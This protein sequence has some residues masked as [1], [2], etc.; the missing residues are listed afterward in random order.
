MA[1]RTRIPATGEPPDD[2]L[3]RIEAFRGDDLDWRG[4]RT[5]SLVYDAGPDHQ[6]LLKRAHAAYFSENGLNP[7]AFPGLKRLETEIVQ[8]TAGLLNGPPS[9]VGTMTSGGTESLLLAVKTARDRARWR[10]RRP[11]IVLPRTAH[12]AFDKAGEWFGVELRHAPVDAQ[13]RA[14]VGAMRR[15]VDRRTVLMVASAPQYPHGSVDPVE[16]IAEIAVR[17]GIP[18]HVDA[19]FGGFLLP[20]LERLGVEVPRW[21]FRVPGVSSIS[22][23]LHKY[24]YAAKGASVL[25]YRDSALMRDQFFVATDWPGGVYASPSM[26]GT[27]P[28]GPI[29]AAWAALRGL[30]EDGYLARARTSWDAA[31]RLRDGI[32]AI[33]ELRLLGLPHSTIVTWA[34]RDDLDVYAVADLLLARGWGVD[35]QQHPA[36]V[37]CT[38]SPA[39]APVVDVYLQDL[40]DAVAEVKRHPERRAQ[41]EAAMYGLMARLPVRRLVKR[42]VVDVMVQMHGPDGVMPAL[43]TP[44][45][46]LEGALQRHGPRVLDA[47]ERVGLVRR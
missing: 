23:D 3:A 13:G 4:G 8:M 28:A 21:D 42:A 16:A 26:P 11:N 34:A 39:N 30:G 24:G 33:P 44:A 5:W 29:A 7:M 40:R 9:C 27:R 35:R 31:E 14:D 41:G 36:S 19:C 45:E 18:L 38:V 1:V 20:W 15:L 25:L 37:H 6:A 17:R 12:V 43:D 46:G 22:A 10:L 2:V 32:R 47:L